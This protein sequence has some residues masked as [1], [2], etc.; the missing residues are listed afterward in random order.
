LGSVARFINSN[1]AEEDANLV[2]QV[3]HRPIFT[4]K[5]RVS[6]QTTSLN[7]VTADS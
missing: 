7:P 6:T 1:E 5:P 2:V 4:T 3:R